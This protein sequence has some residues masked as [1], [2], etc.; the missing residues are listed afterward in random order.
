[1]DL[2]IDSFLLAESSGETLILFFFIIHRSIT[3]PENKK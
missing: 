1:M 2:R 3:I